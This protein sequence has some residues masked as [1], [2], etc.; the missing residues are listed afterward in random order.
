MPPGTNRSV[1]RPRRENLGPI[2]LCAQISAAQENN[3]VFCPAP[4]SVVC[5]K[6]LYLYTY[7]K[8]DRAGAPLPIT[9]P[10]LSFAPLSVHPSPIPLRT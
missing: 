7:A 3:Q 2:H 6:S 5:L 10:S 8:N 9:H 4:A 1:S